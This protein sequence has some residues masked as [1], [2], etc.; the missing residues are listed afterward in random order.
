MLCEAIKPKCPCDRTKIPGVRHGLGSLSL[1]LDCFSSGTR[2]PVIGE[3]NLG[4]VGVAR[5]GGC[6]SLQITDVLRIF[7]KFLRNRDARTSPIS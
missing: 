1:M 6:T 3:M 5:Q 2:G 4:V 7:L